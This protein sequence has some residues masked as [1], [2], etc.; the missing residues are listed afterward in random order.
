MLKGGGNNMKV[1]FK[2]GIDHNQEFLFPKKLSEFLPED[3]LAKTIKEIVEQ[4]NLS[5]IEEKYSEI[6][7]HAYNPKIMVSLLF[8]GYAKGIRSSRKISE[9]CENRFD[10]IFLSDG[11]RPSHDRI[12]DFRKENLEELKD[13]FN[14]IVLTGANLGLAKIGNINASIDG[15][16]VKANASPKLSKDEDG[17]LNLLLKTDEE[18]NKMLSEAEQVDS[19]EDQRYGKDKRGDE[20]PKKL[21]SKQS[22][23][24]AIEEALEKLKHQKEEAKN[25]IIEEKKR[26]PTE[27]EMKKINKMKINVTDND[28]KFMQERKGVI[29]PNYNAQLSI[30]EKE[31]FILANDVVNECNDQ[32]QLVSMTQKTK[33]NLGESPK[34]V[35]ADNGYY[36]ELEKAVEKFPKT[37]FY[38]DDKNRRK[39][40]INLKELK[41]KYNKIQFKNL[42]KLLTKQG[43]NQY[44]KRMYTVEPPIGD[45][46]YNLGYKD[47]LLRGTDKARGE[48]NLMCTAHNLK[49][50][51]KKISVKKKK[52][53]AGALL[54]AQKKRELIRKTRRNEGKSWIGGR[55]DSLN[56][57]PLIKN[58]FSVNNSMRLF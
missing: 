26:E 55:K 6:G 18:I 43:E 7:Q 28:A 22:R 4:L 23:K 27:S 35:N 33:E 54:K 9:E 45:L 21:K 32:H 40:D 8:Y 1:K 16:K 41:E 10:F 25:K 12:S 52:N 11:Q 46:K 29:K 14:I 51:H 31:Q 15:T 37:D 3:H 39:K 13:I 53:L 47:F 19:E 42:K 2:Q 30:D 34:K 36:P 17:L 50:I 24:K 5:N 57:L 44:K 58:N 56:Q 38:V 20:L 49:K 48:F